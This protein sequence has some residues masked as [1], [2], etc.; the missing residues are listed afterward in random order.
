MK[1]LDGPTV[2]EWE[3]SGSLVG[4]FGFE[5]HWHHCV[6]SLSKTHLSLFSTR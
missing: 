5:P 1:H 6:V 2:R 4:G 3:H